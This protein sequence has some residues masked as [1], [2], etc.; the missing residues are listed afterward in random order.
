MHPNLGEKANKK[1]SKARN[2]ETSKHNNVNKQVN[3][4][5]I[6]TYG[7]NLHAMDS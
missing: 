5:I 4:H 2:T 7:R 1:T 6:K 3:E